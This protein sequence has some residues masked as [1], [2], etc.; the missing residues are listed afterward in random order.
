MKNPKDN[1][2]TACVN[3]VFFAPTK[4]FQKSW[5]F[6]ISLRGVQSFKEIW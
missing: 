6:S 3:I 5:K 2:L 4:L 1:S